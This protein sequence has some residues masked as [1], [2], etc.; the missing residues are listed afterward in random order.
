[1]SPVAKGRQRCVQFGRP[2]LV[3]MSDP[4]IQLSSRQRV[5][6]CNLAEKLAL[7]LCVLLLTAGL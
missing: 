1:M 4:L 5:W 2:L 7:H 6:L 3:D